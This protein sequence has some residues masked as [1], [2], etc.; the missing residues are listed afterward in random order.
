MSKHLTVRVDDE[1]KMLGDAIMEVCKESQQD[2]LSQAYTDYV[3]SR[4]G[5][6]PGTRELLPIAYAFIAQKQKV[7]IA[8][9]HER[10]EHYESEKA[11]EEAQKIELMD[12][13]NTVCETPEGRK[14]LNVLAR[15]LQRDDS[16]VAVAD[17][18]EDDPD[19][20]REVFTINP[21]DDDNDL[22]TT[23]MIMARIHTTQP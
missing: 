9:L 19:S 4:V 21:D 11:A 5:V 18:F 10:M 20:F 16:R 23:A 12:Q 2:I 8:Q 14:L 22:V 15:R 17:V 3:F 7:A 13:Y 1:M 6:V